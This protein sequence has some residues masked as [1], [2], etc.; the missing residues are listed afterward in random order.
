M[1]LAQQGSQHDA[2]PLVL[3]LPKTGLIDSYTVRFIVTNSFPS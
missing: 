3:L 2:R 1:S